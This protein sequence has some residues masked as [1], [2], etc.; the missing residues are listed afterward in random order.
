MRWVR[1][2]I[3]VRNDCSDLLL[4][5]VLVQMSVLS[6][7]EKLLFDRVNVDRICV[8]HLLL[9]LH[10]MLSMVPMVVLR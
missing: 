4:S 7:L 10:V 3:I 8:L 5:V 2:R 9:V 1:P 6:T